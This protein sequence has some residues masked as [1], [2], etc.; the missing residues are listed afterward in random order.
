MLESGSVEW[1][2]HD[3]ADVEFGLYPFYCSMSLTYC[4]SVPMIWHV[5]VLVASRHKVVLAQ[6]ICL[7]MVIVYRGRGLENTGGREHLFGNVYF[8]TTRAAIDKRSSSVERVDQ[9]AKG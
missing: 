6:I 5:D 9:I 7:Y 4:T 3:I 1:F 2:C 8:S